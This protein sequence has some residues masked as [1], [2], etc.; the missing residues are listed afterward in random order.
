MKMKHI[1][2]VDDKEENLYLLHTLLRGNGYEVT[3]AGHG[4]EALEIARQNP[5]D[6]VI[7]DILMPV[8]D[9]FALCRE[10][11]KD[12]LLKSIPLVF[13]SATY[14]EERDRKF[15]LSLGA[16]RFIVK[17]AEP[18]EFMDTVKE[19]FRQMESLPA[20]AAPLQPEAPDKEESVYLK[21]Y[22]EV[23][24]HKLEAKME[25][26]EQT[27]RELEQDIAARKLAEE[28]IQRFN[29]ELERQIA[30]R[31]AELRSAVAH[32]EEL[33][34]VFVGRELK[35]IELKKRITELEKQ[36]T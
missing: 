20:A 6:M 31:T 1:L 26:L 7:T 3:T 9:G 14:T 32:L 34:R 36:K 23:L 17:P 11:K 27:N 2:V 4:A 10:W 30:E 35:M 22:N 13:Y 28:K 33:N 25:Q 24:V 15:A 21:E 5:P 19:V 29:E 12:K 8:M 16:E 18:D